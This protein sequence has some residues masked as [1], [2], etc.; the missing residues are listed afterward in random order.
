MH[1][2]LEGSRAGAMAYECET[3]DMTAPQVHTGILGEAW[4]GDAECGTR[5]VPTADKFAKC[6]RALAE[7]R[8]VMRSTAAARQRRRRCLRNP[9]PAQVWN[10]D[11]P[12]PHSHCC[13]H[14]DKAGAG[15]VDMQLHGQLPARVVD[16]ACASRQLQ[17]G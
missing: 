3:K 4:A 7:C 1:A 6:A 11:R 15:D 8:L 2:H 5:T 12:Q 16:A 9:P 10:L 17:R 13:A 14:L